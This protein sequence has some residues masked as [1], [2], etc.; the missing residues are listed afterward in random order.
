MVSAWLSYRPQRKM[1]G[2]LMEKEEEYVRYFIREVVFLD[3]ILRMFADF[4]RS[5]H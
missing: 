5:E 1:F 3:T 4:T 2:P